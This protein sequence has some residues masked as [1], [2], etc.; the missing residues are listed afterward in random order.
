MRAWLAKECRGGPSESDVE[1]SGG[2][3]ASAVDMAS[4]SGGCGSLG[5][6]DADGLARDILAGWDVAKLALGVG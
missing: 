4:G 5:V 3:L 1:G 2:G 6:R